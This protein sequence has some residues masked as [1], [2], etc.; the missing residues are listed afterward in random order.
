ML[1][2]YELWERGRGYPRLVPVPACHAHLPESEIHR[3]EEIVYF[4]VA[5][6]TSHCLLPQISTRRS[7]L[8]L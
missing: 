6:A 8:A 5:F 2:T 4:H 1:I 3:A 7:A